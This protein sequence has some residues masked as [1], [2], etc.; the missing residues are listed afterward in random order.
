M[1]QESTIT[2]SASDG[3][4]WICPGCNS[5]NV[6]IMK[7]TGLITLLS[8]LLFALPLPI[9]KKRLYCF[10]CEFEWKKD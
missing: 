3:N 5:D 7:R 4:G 1:G 10:D 8:L 6:V 2:N 9:F